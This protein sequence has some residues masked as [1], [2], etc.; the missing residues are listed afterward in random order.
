MIKQWQLR[1]FG[2]V[3]GVFIRASVQEKAKILNITGFVRNLPDG[4]VEIN[5]VGE[6]SAL[7]KLISWLESNPGPSEITHIDKE[8]HDQIE[9]FDDFEILY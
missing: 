1:L 9:K 7:E 5:A 3:Q 2:V 8:E 6:L 4:K